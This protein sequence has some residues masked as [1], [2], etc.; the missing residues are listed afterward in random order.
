M[1][2][3]LRFRSDLGLASDSGCLVIRLAAPEVIRVSRLQARGQVFDP[4][5]DG[6][7]RSETELDGVEVDF[8]I[9]NDGDF[10]SVKRR[11]AEIV[12]RL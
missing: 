12:S 2:D 4:I 1:L 9:V 7:H 10:D 8:E 11:L 3:A 6:T 5:V